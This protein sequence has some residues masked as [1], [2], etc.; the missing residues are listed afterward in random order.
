MPTSTETVRTFRGTMIAVG[1]ELA[2][3]TGRRYIFRCH[4]G[5]TASRLSTRAA[6]VK[7]D[8]CGRGG[9]K[10][11]AHGTAVNLPEPDGADCW[12]LLSSADDAA[13]RECPACTKKVR[14]FPVKGTVNAH[15]CDPRCMGATGPR[16]ECSCGG[17]NHGG[18]FGGVAFTVGA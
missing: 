6:Q 2:H 13:V 4:C 7:Y 5:W 3:R 16:C 12:Y 9:D 8:R 18:A 17:A 14:G 1:R 15:E 11:E 10:V